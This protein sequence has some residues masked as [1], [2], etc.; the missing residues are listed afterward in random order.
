MTTLPHHH[1]PSE[2]PPPPP[3]FDTGKRPIPAE[4][5]APESPLN[6][7][8]PE[9]EPYPEGGRAAYLSLLGCFCAWMSAFGL[10]NTIGTFQA[11]LSTHQLAAYSEADIGWIFSLYLFMAYCCGV[12]AGPVFDAIGPRWLTVAG[13]VFLVLAMFLLEVCS[14]GCYRFKRALFLK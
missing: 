4:P 1:P 3:I 11:Y 12:Q 5:H 13:S 7:A 9:T 6:L 14:R 8:V 2:N 10:M